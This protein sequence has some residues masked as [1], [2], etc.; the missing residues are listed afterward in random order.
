MNAEQELSNLGGRDVMQEMIKKN[1]T[2]EL[3]N[4]CKDTCLKCGLKKSRTR[5]GVVAKPILTPDAWIRRQTD[6]IDVQSQAD[7]ES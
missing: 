1:I 7:G 4:A 6:L 2:V 5:K 3:F